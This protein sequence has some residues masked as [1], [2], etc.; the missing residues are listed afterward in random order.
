MVLPRYSLEGVIA[1]PDI[2]DRVS[3]P[4]R[5]AREKKSESRCSNAFGG[6]SENEKGKRKRFFHLD[7]K[8]AVAIR[9][10]CD[11]ARVKSAGVINGK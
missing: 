5:Y 10:T 11:L 8:L 9:A 3:R 1:L 4:V 7:E 6:R 2:S